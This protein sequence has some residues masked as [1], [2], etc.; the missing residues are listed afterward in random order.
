M[1]RSPSQGSSAIGAKIWGVALVGFDHALGPTIEFTH[2]DS[3]KE[4]TEL[5]RN[6]PFLALPDGAHARDEDYSYFHLL[7][8]SVAPAQTIFG[9]SCNRQIPADQLINK[10]KDVTRSTVQKAIVVLASK[11]IFGALRDKLGVVTR[12]FFAQRNFDDKAILVDLFR[13]FDPALAL[14]KGKGRA[15]E[16]DDDKDEDDEEIKNGLAPVPEPPLSPPPE[17]KQRA[18]EEDGGMYMG[19]SLRELVH[20]FRFKTLMLLKLVMLQR[21]VMFFAANSPVE[22]LCTFQYSLVTL[23]PA[24]LTALDDAASP[25]L[26]ERAHRIT[27]PSSLKTSDKYSLI[28][29]LGL[30]LDVFGKGSFF[31][32]YLPLQQIDLLKTSSYLVGTTNSIFQQQR[33]CHIDVIVNIDS[34]SLEVLN[35]K[36]TPLITLTAADRKWMDELVTTVDASWNAADPARPLGQGF[37]GSD[38]FLRAKFEEYVCSLLACV[39]FGEFLARERGER[40]EML[41]SA[42]ELESYNPASFNEAFINAFK[43]TSAFE[44][45]DRTTDEVIFDLVEPKHPMEGKTNPIEDVGI[46]LVHGLHDLSS[47]LSPALAPLPQKARERLSKGWVQ[48]RDGVWGAVEA[49]REDWG[50]RQAAAAAAA[51]A[52]GAPGAAVDANGEPAGPLESPLTPSQLGGTFFAGVDVARSGAQQLAAGL[53]GFLGGAARKTNLFGGGVSQPVAGGATVSPAPPLTPATAVA[54]AAAAAGGGGRFLRP[55][56][57]AAAATVPTSPVLGASAGGAPLSPLAAPPA[58]PVPAPALSPTQGGGLAGFFGGLRRIAHPAVAGAG[59]VA[60]GSASTTPST[61]GT[62]AGFGTPPPLSFLGVGGWG[63][64]AGT[65]SAAQSAS[66]LALRLP[67]EAERVP[68][69]AREVAG[70]LGAEEGHE[71]DG[72]EDE[73]E[74]PA[75]DGVRARVIDADAAGAASVRR[76]AAARED[77]RRRL[78]GECGI[79]FAIR[80]STSYRASGPTALSSDAGSSP[81]STGSVAS[82]VPLADFDEGMNED[83]PEYGI[84]LADGSRP[85]KFLDANET[86]E[87]VVQAV[88]SRGPDAS[89]SLIKHVRTSKMFHFEMRFHASVLHMRGDAL[90]LQPFVADNGDVF[91]W[92]G[93]IFDG[94]EVSPH[95]NDGQKLFEQIQECGP[96]NFFAAIRDVEGPY[97]FV[98]YQASTQRVYFARDPLGR[99][100]LLFHPPTPASPYLFLASNSPGADFPL[101]EW[102][103][104]ACD[105]VHCYHLNDLKGKSWLVDG[106]RGLSSYP[107]YPKSLGLSQDILVYPFDPLVTSLPQPGS[108]TPSSPANPAEPVITSQLAL[109]IQSFIAELE[110]AIRARVATVPSVPAPPDARIAILFSGGLDCT[111]LAAVLD[112]VLPDGEAVDLINVAFENPR[113]LKAKQAGSGKGKE[114]AVAAVDAMD[115]DEMPP[116]DP[117]VTSKVYDV[118][119]R[120]TARDS[121]EELKRLRPQRKWNLIEVNVPYREM[122]EHRQTVIDLMKPQ[123]TVMDLSISIA[124]WFAARGKGH[125]SQFDTSRTTGSPPLPAPIPYH[126]RARVLLSG[127]GADEQLGG[128]ARHRKAFAQPVSPAPASTSASRPTASVTSPTI[129][130]NGLPPVSSS[131]PPQPSASSPAAPQNWSA[132]LAELQLDLD[133]LP[134]RNLGRDDRILSSHGKEARYPYLAGHVVAFLARQPVWLKTD[135]R[136]PEGTGDKMLLRLVARRLGLV[137]AASLPKKAAHFGSGTAKME[138]TA[139]RAKGTDLL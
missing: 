17:E 35:P 44:L 127:L 52:E 7:L 76:R 27:K 60:A 100:S 50:K 13:S 79:A 134:T 116:P 82:P 19:T 88:R 39:K 124:F 12:S 105:G 23:I 18:A 36:L 98:Y 1:R 65:G 9:I 20:R 131:T 37:V 66:S 95:E 40:A 81:G 99:R 118:P 15:E 71:E 114:K 135:Y 136:F 103:E 133:R 68:R 51:A 63:G 3:L 10:G 5:Q 130:S 53:G 42:P 22:Q 80:S 129:S 110:R 104:V 121:W 96:S 26:D 69:T 47:D 117:P 30:P 122:L 74:A 137:K 94:L 132:L 56:S 115:V 120:L 93:E 109:V 29:Y 55:L 126:S 97:A 107:R 62:P 90:T 101:Q 43:R 128:Y 64:R 73:D 72:T 113:K 54:P 38:D 48:G 14:E 33:D 25:A 89:N 41:L 16:R 77:A 2:P 92:N 112:R 84:P 24:L 32:P 45:W 67:D 21:R 102:E 31:Q 46:R 6:L 49:I 108:L 123:R 8:P 28:R 57:T 58:A 86:W 139:G 61:P 106:R 85:D 91:L 70:D 87:G 11:P 78:E 125:F 4:N 119:D 83:G 75:T 34:A 111:V 59:V 138:L